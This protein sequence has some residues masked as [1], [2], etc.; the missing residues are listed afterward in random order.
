MLLACSSSE[1]SA[2]GPRGPRE[3]SATHQ[4]CQYTVCII[5]GMMQWNTADTSFFATLWQYAGHPRIDTSSEPSRLDLTSNDQQ[6]YYAHAGCSSPG[7]IVLNPSGKR[8]GRLGRFSALSKVV[9]LTSGASPA[10][11]PSTGGR[12]ASNEPCERKQ[13]R[14]CTNL[15]RKYTYN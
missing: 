12:P 11:Y 2:A 1:R 14:G 8:G 13:V 15:Q 3:S 9:W 6:E 5:H 4:A 7:P 10:A